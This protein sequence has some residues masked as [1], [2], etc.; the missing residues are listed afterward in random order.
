MNASHEFDGLINARWRLTMEGALA[1]PPFRG[2]GQ[3][4]ESDGWKKKRHMKR[5]D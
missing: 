5:L 4:I 2:T 3:R 1:K